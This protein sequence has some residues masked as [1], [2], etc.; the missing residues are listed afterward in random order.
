MARHIH[1]RLKVKG[2]LTAETALHVGGLGESP[3]TDMPLARNGKGEYYIPGTSL[4]GSLRS[5]FEKNFPKETNDLWGY[6][7]EDKG[8]ASFVLIEDMRI[9]NELQSS[10]RSEVRD[11]VGIDRRYGTAADK[12]K[13]DRAILPK[14]TKL[15]FTIAVEI[16]KETE[17]KK[18]KAMF[19]HLLEALRTGAI[20]LGAS[21][22]RGLGKVTFAPKKIE[23]YLLVGND[24]NGIP[25]VL[26]L[27]SGKPTKS[28]SIQDLIN[29]DEET[30]PQGSQVLTITVKWQPKSALMVKASYEGIGVDTLPLV[31]GIGDGRVSLVLPGSSIKGAFRAHAERIIRTLTNDTASGE[32]FHDQIKLDI[33]SEL[34]GA[35]KEKNE[36]E[37]L[38]L[39]ALSFDDCYATKSVRNDLWNQVETAKITKTVNSKEED[40]TFSE[41]E[42]WRALRQVD[43]ERVLDPQ[44]EPDKKEI[45]KDTSTFKISHHV[46]I[47]RWTGGA[48]EGALYGVLQPT[49]QISWQDI[50]L[51]LDLSR[52]P[53][54]KKADGSMDD[55]LRKK[56]LML[57]L[58]VLRDFAENRLPL[59]FATNRGMGEVIVKEIEGLEVIPQLVGIEDETFKAEIRDGKVIF[60][61]DKVKKE[62][63]GVWNNG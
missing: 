11:G 15:G 52:I 14:G 3:D 20:R 40:V 47:D 32:E 5:W 46:A 13:F 19:G 51:M 44:K 21:K 53:V 31:S 62:L 6:Q 49:A 56:C 12:A 34:F 16:E 38:G 59:G 23:E 8:H 28:Y 24:T 54:H 18:I 63:E 36:E 22:T 25:H 35:K 9:P 45:E 58:L 4:T 17:A 7:K 43:L 39:G 1:S 29:A 48:S 30:K 57:L 55:S 27:V 42:L 41:Q 26:N 10:I 33:V 50:C 60:T 2:T 61:G 37:H